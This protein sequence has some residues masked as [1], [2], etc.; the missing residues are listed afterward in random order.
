MVSRIPAPVNS[1]TNRSSPQPHPAHRGRAGLQRGEEV[2]IQLHR[3]RITRRGGQRLLGEHLALDHR[4]DQL[5]EA[6]SAFHPADDQVPRLDQARL[7]AVQPG[8]RLRD[9]GIAVHEG[10]LNQVRFDEF[11]EQFQHELLRPPRRIVATSWRSAISRSRAAGGV[12][13]VIS[14]PSFADRPG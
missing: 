7:G 12:S 11:A 10:G 6:G 4:I 1:I 2:L 3:L 14:S 8:Q 9:R 13:S 5:G